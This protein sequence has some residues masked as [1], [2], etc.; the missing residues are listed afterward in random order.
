MDLT[1][2]LLSAGLRCFTAT[3]CMLLCSLSL[4]RS[5]SHKETNDELHGRSIAGSFELSQP[6]EVL[7]SLYFAKKPSL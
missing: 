1:F 2:D 3:T 7:A 4:A 5:A 6:S